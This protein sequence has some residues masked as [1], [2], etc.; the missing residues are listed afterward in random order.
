M[1][2]C[3]AYDFNDKKINK[4]ISEL[5]VK[6]ILKERAAFIRIKLEK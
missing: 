3:A 6:Q 2:L 5:E 1:A 4:I